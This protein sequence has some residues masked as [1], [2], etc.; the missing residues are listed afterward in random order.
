MT[1]FEDHAAVPTDLIDLP[2]LLRRA[3]FGRDGYTAMRRQ[4][5]TPR[6][7]RFGRKLWFS[8]AEVDE[9]LATH[10][11]VVDNRAKKESA[12]RHPSA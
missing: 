4:G 9:W 10:R 6:A 11:I 1:P 12:M 2:E 5:R 7:F 8:E 3:R